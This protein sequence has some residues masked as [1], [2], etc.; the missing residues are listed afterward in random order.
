MSRNIFDDSRLHMK[1]SIYISEYA[2]KSSLKM[3]ECFGAMSFFFLAVSY[4]AHTFYC[5][6]P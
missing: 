4:W 3:K 1:G 5:C 6:L 2:K